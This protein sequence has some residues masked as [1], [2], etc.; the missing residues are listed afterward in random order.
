MPT[1]YEGYAMRDRLGDEPLDGWVDD[2]LG[3]ILN[4]RGRAGRI[5]CP[6]RAGR[7]ESGD[8]SRQTLEVVDSATPRSEEE[9]R[10]LAGPNPE[11]GVVCGRRVPSG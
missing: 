5:S 8:G 2:E 4:P 9:G 6:A 1:R 7:A 11:L 3:L 10:A